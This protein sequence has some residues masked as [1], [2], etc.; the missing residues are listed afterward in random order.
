MRI[1]STREFDEWLGKL[2]DLKARTSIYA[3]M[4]AI[5]DAGQLLGDIQPIS[6]PLKEMRFHT[7]AGYRV[8]FIQRGT[9]LIL[10]LGG[11]NKTSQNKDIRKL[12]KLCDQWKGWLDNGNA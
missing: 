3:R 12:Q 7:G 4:A 11:G 6:E 8:Y 1:E 2:R 5:R 10:V 9:T